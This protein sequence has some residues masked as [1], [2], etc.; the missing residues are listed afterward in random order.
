MRRHLAP[1][2]YVLQPHLAPPVAW[3]SDIFDHWQ[4][5]LGTSSD[6]R[7]VMS[8]LGRS[9]RPST[10]RSYGSKWRR[11]EDFCTSAGLEAL[12]A[13]PTTVL[14]YLGHLAAEG[15]IHA[16]HLQPYFSAINKRHLDLQLPP[17]AL[18]PSLATAR[19]GLALAQREVAETTQRLPLPASSALA[20]LWCGL[21]TSDDH[22]LRCCTSLVFNF[23]F[24]C[25]PATGAAMRASDVSVTAD[26]FCLRLET[27]KQRPTEL[28]RRVLHVPLAFIAGPLQLWNRWTARRAVLGSPVTASAYVWSL[29]SDRVAPRPLDLDAWFAS[30][31]AA[32]G[33]HAPS[34]YIVSGYTARKGMATAAKSIGVPLEEIKWLG[35][36]AVGSSA[37]YSYIDMGVRPC[38]AA[39]FWYGW[40]LKQREHPPPSLCQWLEAARDAHS[41]LA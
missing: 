35:G 12:P 40:L 20:V 28:E 26:E 9:L 10:T 30:A 7:L 32:A 25:R 24:G 37:V 16:S 18:G 39:F 23:L 8:L 29:P 34:G 31:V 21:H 22:V 33:F 19:R 41:A 3:A 4:R 36:W 13:A 27:E 11:F 38:P 14:R 17:P 1:G 15:R 6:S 2:P 5:Q